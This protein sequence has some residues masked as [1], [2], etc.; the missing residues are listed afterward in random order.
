MR[1][2]YSRLSENCPPELVSGSLLIAIY[3]KNKIPNR[4]R[5]DR[6]SIFCIPGQPY[7]AFLYFV[8]SVPIPVSVKI[9]SSSACGILPSIM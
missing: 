8:I 2:G 9:S 3:C 5:N 6:I 1:A 4:V 7:K